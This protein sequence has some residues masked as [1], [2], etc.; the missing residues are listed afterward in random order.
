MKPNHKLRVVHAV[1]GPMAD[2]GYSVL[3][4]SG[5][6]VHVRILE[7]NE[8]PGLLFEITARLH[9]S[10][11]IM[12]LLLLTDALHRMSAGARIRLVCPYFPYARQDRV[13]APGEALSLRVVAD[14]INAQD[15]ES[16]E[17][18]DCP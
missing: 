2:M 17:I 11:E 14:L 4:F 12:E 15:Y 10:F 3:A 1:G 6:E 5:G 13:C 7:P 18:T 8:T 16:V 9:G